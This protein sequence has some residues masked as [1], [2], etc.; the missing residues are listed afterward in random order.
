MKKGWLWALAVVVGL[1]LAIPAMAV[2]FSISGMNNIGYRIYRNTASGPDQLWDDHV[3]TNWTQRTHLRFNVKA[4]EDL[5]GSVLFRMD[6]FPHAWGTTKSGQNAMGTWTAEQVAV[7]VKES[8]I[9]FKIPGIDTPVWVRAGV[10]G[11]A[12]RPWAFLLAYGGGISVRGSCDVADGKLGYGAGWGKILEYDENAETDEQK[13]SASLFYALLDYKGKGPMGFGAYVAVVTGEADDYDN[14]VGANVDGDIWWIGF[15]SD[16]KIGPVNYNLDVIFNTGSEDAKGAGQDYDYSGWMARA[17]LTYP[18]DRFN[19]GLGGAYVSGEDHGDA[20]DIEGFVGV[21]GMETHGPNAD[22]VVV[23]GGWNGGPG[24]MGDIG[25]TTLP[26][27]QST[28]GIMGLATEGWPGIWYVRLFADYKALDW[29]TLKAQVAYFGDT[30]EDGNAFEGATSS[31]YDDDDIGFEVDLGA[32]V[33]IYKNLTWN[34]A[35]GY[36]FAGDACDGKGRY[37]EEEDTYITK[38]SDDPY[39][40]ISTLIFT[41]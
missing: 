35:F 18:Y 39:G 16:G 36:L 40:F 11:F 38:T 25:K 13:T 27:T 15:Y 34:L 30:V 22:S 12:I 8:Y 9:D 41:F 6:S 20:D 32:T 21:P 1:A 10:Q 14:V 29:L 5:M 33:N 24:P 4:S 31:K 19:F 23:L 28:V 26:M 17:V 3:Y 37:I 2:D 7:E